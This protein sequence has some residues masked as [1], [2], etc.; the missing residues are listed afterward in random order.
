[1]IFQY[2]WE[3]VLLQ[4]ILN[5]FKA[6]LEKMF[7]SGAITNRQI[8]GWT[9]NNKKKYGALYLGGGKTRNTL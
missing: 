4:R 9:Y 3:P 1:M 8:L 7:G 2:G 6:I 5:G